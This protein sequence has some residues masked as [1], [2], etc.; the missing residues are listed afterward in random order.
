[1][2]NEKSKNIALGAGLGIIFGAAFV[3]VA[4]G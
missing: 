1:M 3:G 4:I 2:G